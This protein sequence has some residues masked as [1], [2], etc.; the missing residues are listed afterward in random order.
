MNRFFTVDIETVGNDVGSICQIGAALFEYG[1]LKDTFQTN[2]SPELDP[3]QFNPYSME[4][5]GLD[6]E[7]FGME[8]SGR[9]A[10]SELLKW[11]GTE[12]KFFH[13]AGSEPKQLNHL[14]DKTLNLVNGHPLVKLNAP[15]MGAP[16]GRERKVK[17]T[18]ERLGRRI[19]PNYKAHDALEDAV[20]TGRVLLVR[21]QRLWVQLG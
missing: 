8:I 2:C 12:A 14:S 10:V 18:L 13:W 3:D 19:D 15:E 9:E 21:D 7:E 6:V 11:A 20:M 17:F 4:V 5:H 1:E 16:K